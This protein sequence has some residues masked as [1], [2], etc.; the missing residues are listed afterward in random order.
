MKIKLNE[1]L[2][3]T[4]AGAKRHDIMLIPMLRV[5]T[6]CPNAPRSPGGWDA[7]LAVVRFTH[8]TKRHDIHHRTENETHRW[9]ALLDKPAVAP[10]LTVIYSLKLNVCT[11]SRQS[12]L[13]S[14]IGRV[15]TRAWPRRPSRNMP[16][17]S[18][19][20]TRA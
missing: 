5:G 1:N 18:S 11:I 4:S 3:G 7:P 17:A 13:P 12:R 14:E 19:I 10:Y 20:G 2:P 6:H 9:P 15:W 8:P 16:W